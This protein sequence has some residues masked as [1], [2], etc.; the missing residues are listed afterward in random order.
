MPKILLGTVLLCLPVLVL[1][2]ASAPASRYQPA[3]ITQVKLH[4]SGDNSAPGDAVYEVSVKVNGTT[5]VVLTKSPSGDSTILYA[6]GREL[7]VHIDE[8]TITWN[9]ILGQSHEAPIITKG[10]IADSSKF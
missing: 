4:Q 2:Q 1:A 8:N 3:T 7:L 10:P 5:Y 6:S 9:D